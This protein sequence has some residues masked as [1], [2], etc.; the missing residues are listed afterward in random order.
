MEDNKDIED[1]ENVIKTYE[2][3]LLKFD[4]KESKYNEFINSLDFKI[5]NIIDKEIIQFYEIDTLPTILI[6]KNKNLIDSIKGFHTKSTL[7]KKIN[8]LIQN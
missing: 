8:Y 4:K 3:I 7:L 6:Y 1:I 5:T 2:I